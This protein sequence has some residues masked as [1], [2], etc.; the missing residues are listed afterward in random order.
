MQHTTQAIYP[1]T[2]EHRYTDSTD[3]QTERQADKMVIRTM[4][5]V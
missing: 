3:R 2:Y 1:Q 5:T 4:T